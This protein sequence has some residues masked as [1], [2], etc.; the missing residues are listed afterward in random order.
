MPLVHAMNG[1]AKIP[2]QILMLLVPCVAL[3][4]EGKV[5][6]IDRGDTIQVMKDIGKV[7]TVRLY[8][9]G[10]PGTPQ[11]FA[12]TARLYTLKRILGKIVRVDPIITDP[13]HRV[14]A[15]VYIGGESLNKELLRKGMAWWYRK[16]LPFENELSELEEQARKEKVGLWAHPSPIPPWEFHRPTIPSIGQKEE[17][18]RLGKPG[19]IR[20]R[21]K[22]MISGPEDD[23]EK[24]PQQEQD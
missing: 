7:E 14:I 9:I 4:W 10:S 5:I 23:Q 12:E 17:N 20:Q 19:M 16:Y 8:G 18:I 22:E 6:A 11:P 3:A 15:W 21:L 1:F 24:K 2:L 13:Y